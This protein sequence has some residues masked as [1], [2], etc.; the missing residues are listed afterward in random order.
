MP[1]NTKNNYFATTIEH[2]IYI[3]YMRHL[4]MAMSIAAITPAMA[5]T[6]TYEQD[7]TRIV[8]LDEIVITAHSP[9]ENTILRQMPV[10]T[11]SINLQMME[12]YKVEDLKDISSV[13]PNFYMPDYGSR[14]T[15]AIYIR[16][17]GSR[18]NTPAVGMYVDN[19]PYIDKS[20]F[21]FNFY[22]IESIDILRGPQG[23]LYGRNTMGGL[24]NIHTRNPFNY[25]GTD[26]KL[27]LG[28]YNNY[29]ASLTHY[30]RISDKFAFSAGGFYK[31]AGG[32][33]KN[34]YLNKMSDRMNNG[35]GK[36]RAIVRPNERLDIDMA[37]AYEKNNQGGY[38][39]APY[40]PATDQIGEIATNE[41]G[42]YK[43]DMVNSSI[44]I[45]Y[46]TPDIMFT[47]VTGYQ[48]LKDRM[49]MD[50]DFTPRDIYTIEQNQ[51]IHTVSQELILRSNNSRNYQWTTGAFAFYQSLNTNAPVTFKNG[52]I[53]MIQ[54]IMDQAM[55]QSPVKIQ[56]L[57]KEMP[58]PGQYDTP[59]TGAALY[60]QST[61]NNL[62]VKGLSLTVGLRLDYEKMWITHHTS[63]SM[64]AQATMMGKPMGSPITIPVDIQGEEN[65]S[66]LKLLPK[67]ALK[68]DFNN[69]SNIYATVS[70]G[71]RSGGYN[72][73]M[74]SDIVKDKLMSKPDMGGKQSG[75]NTG[76]ENS[77]A[78]IKDIIRY[79]P[80]QTWNYEAGSHIN[81]WN[82]RLNLDMAVF[83]MQTTD[84]QIAMFAPSG[85][86]RM[87]V[88]SGKSRSIGTEL[89]ATVIPVTGLR[90]YTAYGYT[91]AKFTDYRTNE[92]INNETK[93]IDYN[94][95]FIPMVP[96][97]TL[98]IGGDYQFK[99]DRIISF[100][101]YANIGMTYNAA[102]RIY[103]NETNSV[104]Q[105]F[106]GTLNMNIG[107]TVNRL[108]INIWANNILDTAYKTF[109]F[110]TIGKT[111]SDKAGFFQQG[112]PFHIGVDLKYRF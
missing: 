103:F 8:G 60:H 101:D 51:K 50:Q 12:Q 9:K 1:E 91:N 79:K 3:I 20:A 94:G 78:N 77:Y 92:L 33:F 14:L 98:S 32:Y 45:G 104:K 31:Y 81:L 99:C 17:I 76:S 110:E 11:S 61:Y 62:F 59:L 57:D 66:Y 15:S 10:S 106:Y 48:Y 74:F 49:F 6:D 56:L 87:T 85:L 65:D 58:I 109:Y 64:T 30:H 55:A 24:I 89:S 44:K 111:M 90:I 36:I 28:S 53:S 37:V 21:D 63:A 69:K 46:T 27:S 29:S 52:G 19:V 54:D 40:D 75:E 82:N 70:R 96:Q 4:L 34:T 86:G 7:S 72:I 26:I 84:Q 42:R 105:D 108:D 93:D 107:A 67:I 35:G 39:Y 13:V 97:H 112:K 25:Q 71:Y 47:S 16:G 83:Y 22:D 68:Y 95:N 102:G 5:A 38:G 2:N 88:N 100:F 18:I 41:E 73:Q 23:T 80:E 43:R